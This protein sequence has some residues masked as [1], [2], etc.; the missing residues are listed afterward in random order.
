[1]RELK[2]C[3][4]VAITFLAVVRLS[5]AAPSPAPRIS[6]A[7]PFDQ[8]V[9][10]ATQMLHFYEQFL[11]PEHSYT[12]ARFNDLAQL[13]I[14]MGDYAK[15][16]P[17]LQRALKIYEKALGPEHSYTVIV[18]NDL[19]QLYTQMGDYAKAEPLL[20]RALKNNEKVFGLEHRNTALSLHNLAIL[21]YSTRDYA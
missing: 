14:Q 3:A 2:I 11:G 8:K 12:G 6:E 9:Q 10:S 15:A 5:T 21:Y 13:Y 7:N 1:M 16:E 17:L 4:L 19:A 20:Q 18:L